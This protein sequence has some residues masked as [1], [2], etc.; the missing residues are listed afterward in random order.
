MN[1]KFKKG[2]LVRFETDYYGAIPKGVRGT[3][4][5]CNEEMGGYVVDFHVDYGLTHD[6]EGALQG[7]TGLWIPHFLLSKVEDE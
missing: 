3:I 4:V 5:D 7:D 1:Q 6:C 2:D